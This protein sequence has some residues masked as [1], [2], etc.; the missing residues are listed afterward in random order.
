M[1]SSKVKGYQPT[2]KSLTYMRKMISAGHWKP[3]DRIPALKKIA[4][5]IGVS[6]GT[7][8]KSVAAL[9]AERLIEN[10]GSLGFTV[11]PPK[12]SQLYKIN[13]QLFFLKMAGKNVNVVELMEHG[14][15]CVDDSIVQMRGDKLYVYNTLSTKGFY[16]SIDEVKEVAF[17]PVKLEDLVN[18]D[19]D[20]LSKMK[21]KYRR[22]QK[23]RKIANSILRH[24]K[25]IGI[26]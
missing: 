1:L 10:N 16:T 21:K 2:K 18:M 8:R 4:E 3:T 14:G 11:I 15:V 20:E 6:V 26:D 22:Q 24:R 9:E 13:K 25:E 7:V 17:N 23:V 5:V 12:M 19:K